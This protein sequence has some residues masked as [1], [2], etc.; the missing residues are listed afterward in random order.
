MIRRPPRSTLFPYTTLFRSAGRRDD[1]AGRSL[2]RLDDDRRDVV[3]GLERDFRAQEIDAM[4]LAG[5]ECLAERTALARGVRARVHPW[6]QG[7]EAM[8]EAARQ[9]PQHAAGLAVEATPES[10]N[11]LP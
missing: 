8:L 2:N 7:P 4:P 9:Q 10:P 11:P 6:R 3:C 5:R 1:V